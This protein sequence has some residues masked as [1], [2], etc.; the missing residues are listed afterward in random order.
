[1]NSTNSTN[2]LLED[3]SEK[4]KDDDE[5]GIG[6]LVGVACIL[7]NLMVALVFVLRKRKKRQRRSAT[8]ITSTDMDRSKKKIIKDDTVLPADEEENDGLVTSTEFKQF[9]N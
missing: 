2:I 8:E 9:V 6:I 1:M 7:F 5:Y 4:K 3:G